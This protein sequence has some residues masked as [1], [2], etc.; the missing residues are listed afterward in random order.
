[1][2]PHIIQRGGSQDPRAI[3]LVTKRRI[4]IVNEQR[5]EMVPEILRAS[6]ELW[7]RERPQA[8]LRSVSA[9][10][11]CVGL[12]FAS[13]RTWIGTEDIALILQED[14][15]NR[16]SRLD[17][18]RPGDVVVY[19]DERGEIAH[20]GIVLSI[21]PLVATASWMVSILSKWGAEGEYVHL[22]DHIP[23]YCGRPSE[24]WSERR[25]LP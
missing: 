10:Y 7:S 14:E 11:N 8:R 1:M 6:V 24:Y 15:Y 20:I 22:Q 17:E 4:H 3:P 18:V 13:R 12:V 25:Q 9:T 23:H 2:S 21:E 5:S 16:V 19:R